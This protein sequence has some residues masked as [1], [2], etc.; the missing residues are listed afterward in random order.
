[1]FVARTMR[2]GLRVELSSALMRS[3][4]LLV[5]CSQS[6]VGVLS[7]FDTSCFNILY[8]SAAVFSSVLSDVGARYF[9]CRAFGRSFSRFTCVCAMPPRPLASI[10]CSSKRAAAARRSVVTE[11]FWATGDVE[12]AATGLGP[13]GAAV[14]SDVVDDLLDVFTRRGEQ[15]EDHEGRQIYGLVEDPTPD[16]GRALRHKAGKPSEE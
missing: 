9:R 4:S 1:M 8:S 3:S 15:T 7:S 6:V 5:I 2:K 12:G 13:G 14:P 16:K 11:L 10:A